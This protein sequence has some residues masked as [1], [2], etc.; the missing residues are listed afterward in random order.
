MGW[1]SRAKRAAKA[2]GRTAA[3]V[4]DAV[5]TNPVRTAVGYVPGGSRVADAIPTFTDPLAPV[6][7]GVVATNVAQASL[8]AVPPE[9]E[10]AT[11]QYASVDQ[12]DGAWLTRGLGAQPRFHQ[13]GW[14]LDVQPNASAMTLDDDVFVRGDLTIGTYVHE[15]V[16]VGQYQAVGRTAFL[17]S[18]FGMSAVTLAS[19]LVTRQNLDAMRSSPHEASAYDIEARF[20][21]WRGA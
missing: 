11:R 9:Y 13:G 1:W 10:A 19:R 7:E 16:H 4:G 3:K 20:L 14:I 12:A 6:F 18:Y 5:I 8:I 2:V 17:T 21:R 15:L